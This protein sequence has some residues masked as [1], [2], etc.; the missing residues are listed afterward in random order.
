MHGNTKIKVY[1]CCV[2][3]PGDL[4]LLSCNAFVVF[5]V[6][7]LTAA[8]AEDMTKYKILHRS[9][10]LTQWFAVGAGHILQGS[11]TR[12]VLCLLAHQSLLVSKS[13]YISDLAGMK[14]FFAFDYEES[15]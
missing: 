8:S 11:Y 7:V 3:S 9:T 6:T 4:S 12:Y 13:I 5:H 14:G 10:R 15:N 1:N 2:T